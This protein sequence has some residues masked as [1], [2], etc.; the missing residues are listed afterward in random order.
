[1]IPSTAEIIDFDLTNFQGATTSIKDKLLEFT[2]HEDILLPAVSG[3]VTIT[4]AI[5]LSD[6]F[7][8]VGDEDL[9]MFFKTKGFDYPDAL[10]ARLRSYRVGNKARISQRAVVYPIDFTSPEAVF[11]SKTSVDGCYQG[12]ISDFLLA[13]MK[14]NPR[15]VPSDNLFEVDDTS[16]LTKYVAT[17]DTV[18][19]TIE[20]LRKEAQADALN[21]SSAFLFFQTRL[22]YKFTT[23][24][25]LFDQPVELGNDYYFTFN[26]LKN[27]NIPD[28]NIISTFEV[29]KNPD[30]IDAMRDGVYGNETIAIDPL[31]KAVF[32]N[33]FD[34]FNEKDFTKS[35]PHIS[36]GRIAPPISAG[37]NS[38]KSHT[39]YFVSDLVL[40]SPRT[41]I[42]SNSIDEILYG[43]TKHRYIGQ[44]ASLLGSANY[45]AVRITIPGNSRLNAGE[46]I[47]IFM[48]KS[49][50]VTSEL[51]QYDKYLQG[52][53]LIANL[54][55]TVSADGRFETILECIRDTYAVP[56][57]D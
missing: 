41:Y 40:E 30:L 9:D 54:K 18:F 29:I 57:G 1:M 31:R 39:N 49:S 45:V 6:E 33:E 47:N 4:D 15:F 19:E 17:G 43:R 21:G 23:L 34:Y 2:Y 53:Y 36:K 42:Q 26:N 3:R 22:G 37:N 56:I 8:I 16:G 46:V 7:P 5:G 50:A 24:S 48:P 12:R 13:I 25:K 35:G 27:S 28:F 14:Q 20:K 44:R 32:T 10:D 38:Q 52:K 11:D 51:N 55:H